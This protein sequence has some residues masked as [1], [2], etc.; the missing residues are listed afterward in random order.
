M[1]EDI[2]I[3]KELAA[4]E[5]LHQKDMAASKAGDFETLRSLMADWNDNLPLSKSSIANLPKQTVR[6]PQLILPELPL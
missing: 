1:P 3:E 6:L 2:N 4:I 5:Q